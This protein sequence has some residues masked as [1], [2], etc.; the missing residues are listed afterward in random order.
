MHGTSK[1]ETDTLLTR[2]RH[3]TPQIFHFGRACINN[4][5]GAILAIAHCTLVMCSRPEFQ[6]L[7]SVLLNRCDKVDYPTVRSDDGRQIRVSAGQRKVDE[8]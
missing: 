1:T 5:G 3:K 2:A 8:A 6:A 4:V 7:S